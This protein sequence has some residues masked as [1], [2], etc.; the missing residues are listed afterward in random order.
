MLKRITLVLIVVLLI[1]S[2]GF[3]QKSP[4]DQFDYPQ[5]NPIQLPEVDEIKLDNGIRIFLVEDHSFPTIEIEFIF[6]GGIAYDPAE[7]IG[8]A[9]LT[10]TVFRS[11]GNAKLSGDEMDQ[12]LETMAASISAW[13]GQT[14]S[15]IYVSMLKENIDDVMPILQ[16]MLQEPAF[17]EEK[18]ELA[19]I[20]ANSAISRRNDNVNNISN[21][22]FM[23]LIY[24]GTP[25][26]TQTE[27]ETIKNITREDLIQFYKD[28]YQP[29]S[30]I[31][32]VYGGFSKKKMSK[33]LKKYLSSWENQ[34]TLSEIQP[35]QIKK[36]FDY[37]VNF[38]DKKDVNQSLIAIGHLGI[39]MDNP[40]Y[41]A[42]NVLNQI[43]SYDRMFKK[44][45]TD[46]GLAYSVWGFFRSYFS[47][48]GLLYS[49]AQTKTQTTVQ[50]IELML[51]EMK[52]ITEEP[53]TD[54]ELKK[55]KDQI[56]NTFVFQYD[57]KKKIVNRIKTLAYFGYPQD[58]DEQYKNKIES[59]TKEDILAAAKKHLKPEK[60]K[61][62]VLG[63]QEEFDKP[64]STLG[65]V[66]VIDISIPSPSTGADL[67]EASDEALAQG[68]EIVQKMAEKCGISLKIGEI[69]SFNVVME[70]VVSTPMGEMKTLTDMNV[71]L[72][73]K[74][75]GQV[76]TPNGEVSLVI[77]G[78]KSK[79]KTAQGEMPFPDAQREKILE[80]INRTPF[81]LVRNMNEA[82]MQLVGETDFNDKKVYEIAYSLNEN[83][84]FQLY[85]T[86]DHYQLVGMN[87][88]GMTPT[89]P[90]EIT[91]YY[92]DFQKING[93]EIPM[94]VEMKAGEEKVADV[95][96]QSFK[97]NPEFDQSVFEF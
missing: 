87:Y 47:I 4:K 60:V 39:K 81:A 70:Q 62:L 69:E 76:Q 79:I 41:A 73:D 32:A 13:S 83:Q 40:D 42:M 9:D 16:S 29:Q 50:A 74:I 82:K 66:K 93:I 12:K 84:I 20:E 21:R 18:L 1:F 33:T 86:K 78:G 92:S 46:H 25:L 88:S 54:E 90:A 52:K 44:V 63:N 3:A 48:P 26:A 61:I 96:Y 67:P 95:I 7:K 27:Y 24:A 75:F 56:L 14:N 34:S 55:A 36:E 30:T 68:K 53:V 11:G 10:A 64:L 49:G 80:Q 65:D 35:P 45:R 57:S 91:D 38:I 22:E 2:Q 94:K 17:D 19:K 85:I 59:V 58:F 97:L 5:L 77:S 28:Y 31:I 71:I 89:G 72:P 43:L 23:K 51:E 37:S 6:P 8:L 15:G